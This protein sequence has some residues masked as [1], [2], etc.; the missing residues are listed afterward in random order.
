VNGQV[1]TVTAGVPAWAAAAGFTNPMTDPG[2]LIAGGV[3]GT[4]TRLGVGTENYVLTVKSGVPS[5]A[6][7]VGFAN[8]MNAVGDTI[9][10]GASGGATRLAAGTAGYVLTAGGAGVAPAWAA[11]VGFTNPMNAAGDLIAGGSSGTPTRLA[12]GTAGQV[13][14]VNAGAPAWVTFSALVNP[15]TTAGDTIYGGTAGAPTRLAVGSTGQVLTIAAGVPSWATPYT[16]PMTTAGD[17]VLGGV[18]GAAGR[19]GIGTAGQ[20]LTVAG[21]T[22]AWVTFSALTNPMTTA[23]DTIYGGSGGT[24]TRLAAGTNGNVLTLAG[25]VPSWAAPFSNPMNASGDTIYG[26]TS[27]AATRLAKGADG[28]VLT[29]AAGLPSWAAATSAPTGAAGGDLGG[30]YPNPTVTDLTIASEAQYD[31]LTRGASAWQRLAIGSANQVLTVVAGAPAW[32]T[33]TALTNP[34]TTAGDMLYANAGGTPL[35]LG[36]GT[37]GQVLTVSGGIPAWVAPSGGVA[38]WL[39]LYNATAFYMGGESATGWAAADY[40]TASAAAVVPAFGPGQ[41]IVVCIYPNATPTGQEIIAAHNAT[42]GV[43]GWYIAVG[44]NAG[45]RRQVRLYLA[46]LNASAEVALTGSDFTVSSAYVI[47]IVVKADK[48]VRYSVSGGAV[49]TIAALAGTYTAPTS[50]DTYDIGSTRAYS[51]TFYPLVSA[52]IGEVRTYSTELS[53]A[54][55]VAACAGRT[56]GTIPSVASGTVSTDFLPSDF[57]GGIRVKAQVGVTWLLKGGASLRPV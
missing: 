47:A 23:G 21:G 19:L 18:S 57:C 52:L 49:Q 13:L 50:A 11:A 15:M 40:A 6:S 39:N 42:A 44:N 38:G 43:R 30:T 36:V 24:P 4:A 53:D 12:I 26:G 10:G 37:A 8:P 41:S 2:D 33:S 25:G 35:R 3:S 28:Q 55:L 20:V 46:G 29:L 22:A 5:W 48:S 9:Y 16:N 45:A 17:L 7:A 14:T 32:A 31:L 56:T 54:D 1:L 27:G 51:P 34:M